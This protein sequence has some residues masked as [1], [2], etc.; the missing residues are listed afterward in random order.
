MDAQERSVYSFPHLP[1][2][3][4]LWSG[5]GKEGLLRWSY[6][7]MSKVI[8]TRERLWGVLPRWVQ[9]PEGEQWGLQGAEFPRHRRQ[10]RCSFLHQYCAKLRLKGN[11]GWVVYYQCNWY[12]PKSQLIIAVEVQCLLTLTWSPPAGS[13]PP[14]G[15]SDADSSHLVVL[16]VFTTWHQAGG[17]G[18]KK[19]YRTTCIGDFYGP[20]LGGAH[21]TST[22]ISL[23]SVRWPHRIAKDWKV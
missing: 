18:K 8:G 13:F 9:L 3:T 10:L 16:P 11:Q 5:V 20:G 15:F 12:T 22:H 4:K 7:L 1:T 2:A 19:R 6:P 23:A 14:C 21:I 17:R